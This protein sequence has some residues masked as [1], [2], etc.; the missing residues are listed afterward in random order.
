MKGRRDMNHFSLKAGCCFLFLTAF[1]LSAG[2]AAPVPS[3]KNHV[4]SLDGKWRFKLEQEGDIHKGST[5]NARR[6]PIVTPEHPEPFHTLDYKE[7]A[8]W[9]DITV[10][11]NWEMA[12]FS[13]AT[14]DQPDNAIGLY[15]LWIDIP[16]EWKGR[17]VMVNFDG[18]QNGAEVFLNGQPVN[19]DEPSWDRPNYHEA[20]FDPFQADLTPAV[21]FGGKNLLAIRVTKNTS[22]VD[23]DT[24]DYFLLGGV[25][26]TVTLFS[27][28]VTHIR[29]YA[30]RTKILPGSNKAELRVI[31]DIEKPVSGGKVSMQL[32]GYPLL[33]AAVDPQGRVELVQTLENPKLWSAEYPNLYPLNL[34]LKDEQGKTIE[35]IVQ[36]VGVREVM[37][38]D[39]IFLI[40]NVPV[41]LAGMCRHDC[42]A[43]LGSALN[44]EAWRKDIQLMK[45]ANINAIRTSHYPYGAG[46]Y[47]LCDE[48][49]MYVADELAACWCNTKDER[50]APAFAQRAREMTRR[51]RNHPSVVIWAVGNENKDGPNNKVAADEIKKLDPTRPRLVSCKKAEESDVEFDD[52]HYVTPDDIRKANADPRRKRI[53]MIYLE[54]PNNWEERNGA[55]YGCLDLWAA[56]IDRTWQVVWNADYV[57]GS[58]HWEWADRAVADKCPEKIYDYFPRTG[59]NL[60]K[61]K[62]ICDGFRNPRAWYY[63]VKMAFAPIRVDLKPQVADGSVTINVTNHYSFT[64]LSE[65]KTT[66]H[67]FKEGRELKSAVTHVALAPRTSGDIRLD[68]P[69]REL[70]QADALRIDFDHPEG[71]TIATYDLRLRPEPDTSPKLASL[72][73]ADVK[74]PHLNLITVTYGKN[75]INWRWA[76]RYPGHLV[77]ISVRNSKGSAA[78]SQIANEAALYSMPLSDVRAVEADIVIGDDLTK[79]PEGHV[80]ASF[81]DGKFAYEITWNGEKADIQ[82]LGWTFRMPETC[83]HFSWHRKGYWS[84]YPEDHVGRISGTATPD[85]VDVDVT[86]ITRPDAF[87]F[88]STKYECD[89]A[90]LAGKDG[91]GL[92]VIFS[93]DDPHH[94]RSGTSDDG[95]RLLVV[96]KQCSPPR[97]IS[98]RIVNDFY[99]EFEQGSRI[100][101]GITVGKVESK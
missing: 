77:G 7:D 26:R 92:G 58:F 100:K 38:K 32:E 88:N 50:L 57:P 36:R 56:I 80:S 35:Y 71:R 69:A 87:D 4:V 12:G 8:S 46:F 85:S 22:S 45:E 81:A 2:F 30:V 16:A 40:N 31:V 27:V 76:T 5:F 54:N 11:G 53:P 44:E 66:W 29:D 18:I 49:G 1:I 97:D 99:L 64:D 89:W 86:R 60:V 95:K 19:V 14:Y 23:L 15:R 25:Y 6:L 96:N 67:L 84:F 3:E 34:D 101:G 28:P 94:C 73:D 20:G 59:I 42:Y 91:R 98:T 24:G 10:P 9:H 63:H 93:P 82:E 17:N 79:K 13:A 61:V 65:I 52:M 70:A 90:T 33:D 37:I 48:M 72:S 55:D 41:K 39:G 75:S 62:G 43:T 78:A 83:D 47:D 68:L 74:F 21:K 51:D